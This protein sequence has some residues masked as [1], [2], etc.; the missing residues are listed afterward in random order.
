MGRLGEQVKVR[1][2]GVRDEQIPEA[3]QRLEVCRARVHGR[4]RDLEVENR[5]RRQPGD[6]CG[7]DVFEPRRQS[8]EGSLDAAELDCGPLSPPA[9]MLDDADG[10]VEAVVE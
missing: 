2:V 4:H 8:T 10:R 3:L 5:L 6:G 9:V 1:R 7:A